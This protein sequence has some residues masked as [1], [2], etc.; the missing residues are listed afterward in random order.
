MIPA[1]Y[2]AYY[3]ERRV[4]CRHRAPLLQNPGYRGC[5]FPVGYCW[6]LLVT[7]GYGRNT[8]NALFCQFAVA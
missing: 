1:N 7:A 3:A 6:L 2:D 8:N 4:L 5:V